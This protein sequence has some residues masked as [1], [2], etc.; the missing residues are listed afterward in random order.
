MSPFLVSEG[1]VA[2]QSGMKR[3]ASNHCRA[4]GVKADGVRSAVSPAWLMPQPL[5]QQCEQEKMSHGMLGQPGH[6]CTHMW[7]NHSG[8]APDKDGGVPCWDGAGFLEQLLHLV[9][10]AQGCTRELRQVGWVS[11]VPAQGGRG[12]SIA[13]H[14]QGRQLLLQVVWPEGSVRHAACDPP[15]ES[16]GRGETSGGTM[17]TTCLEDVCKPCTHNTV[18]CSTSGTPGILSSHYPQPWCMNTSSS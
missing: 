12:F 6:V 17:C 9:H 18:L 8:R 16:R 10:Q 1:E 13:D 11:E 14:I 5:W 7:C 2:V 4:L 3:E 15:G